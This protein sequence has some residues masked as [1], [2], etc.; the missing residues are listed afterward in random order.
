MP[1]FV[2]ALMLV[3]STSVFGIAYD[4]EIFPFYQA[5]SHGTLT[6]PD[7]V[8]VDF[9][10]L[11]WLGNV[12]EDIRV[13]FVRSAL[14]VNGWADLK[15][16]PRIVFGAT[17]AGTS[18]NIDTAVLA[19]LLGVDIKQVQGY[20]GAAAKRLALESGEIDGDC[21]G[22]TSLPPDW[23]AAR[24]VD[25]VVRLSPTLL[26]GMDPAVPFGGDLVGGRQSRAVYDFLIAPERLGRL[27]MVSGK[28]APQR[29]AALRQAFEQM[30]REPEFLAEAQQFGLT[31]TP[32]SGADVERAVAALYATPPDLVA[33]ARQIAN[34]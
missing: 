4:E 26:P 9:R 18:G 5:M 17:A 33:R 14:G 29:I 15:A 7:K 2:T 24:K 11:A 20:A 16:R 34:E 6:T 12:S 28:V 10:S 30:M 31:V 1:Y 3:L 21:G 23:I 22:W 8:K 25:V 32:M 19:R 27:F 13:C